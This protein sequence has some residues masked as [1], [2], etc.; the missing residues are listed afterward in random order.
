MRNGVVMSARAAL[1][2]KH[3]ASAADG[4]VIAA[5][6]KGDPS[7]CR[8]FYADAEARSR[9]DLKRQNP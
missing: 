8:A 5:D 6:G 7:G 1:A 2:A 3:Y 4:S 9:A